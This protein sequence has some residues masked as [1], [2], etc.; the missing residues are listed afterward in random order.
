MAMADRLKQ[1]MKGGLPVDL[2]LTLRPEILTRPP[3]VR[4]LYGVAP[5]VVMGPKWW[6]ETRQ[7]AYLSTT[8]RCLACGVHKYLAKGPKWLE[9]HELYDVDW[10]RGTSAYV[11]TVPLCHYCHNYCH[12]GRMDAMLEQG[13]MP[14]Y[15]Y[16]AILLHGDDILRRAG[17]TR[18]TYDGPFAPWKEWRMVVNG[19]KY[20]P[21]YKDEEACERAMRKKMR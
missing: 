9:G 19:Q 4:P 10:E 3:I 16:V 6:Y 15:K 12:P 8:Y 14:Q 13:R 20:K 18:Q 5:R 11:E 1:L 2:P 17:L 7:A 21:L